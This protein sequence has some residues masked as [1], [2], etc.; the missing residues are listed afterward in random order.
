M[1]ANIVS[2]E[3]FNMKDD[4]IFINY[5]LDDKYKIRHTLDISNINNIK[6]RNIDSYIF[7]C[8]L[9]IFLYIFSKFSP[10][11]IINI[12]GYLSE[13]QLSYLK[14]WYLKGLGEFFYKNNL[15]HKI[16]LVLDKQAK[17]KYINSNISLEN[18]ALLLNGGGKDSSVSCEILKKPNINFEWLL[19][20]NSISQINV[21]KVSNIKKKV[22]ILNSYQNYFLPENIKYDTFN[23]HKPF[24]LYTSSLACLVGGLKN[25]KY[26]I[27][28]NE[29]SSNYGNLTIN[30]I[31][32]NHQYTKS[33]E[34]EKDFSRYVINNLNVNIKYFSLL[35]PI[36]ELQIAKIFSKLPQYHRVFVSCNR[37]G[38]SKWCQKCSKCAF[39]YLALYPFLDRSYLNKIIGKDLFDDVN[40]L[41]IYEEL[42]GIRKVKPFECVGTIK[43]NLIAM[44]LSCKKSEK[45]KGIILNHFIKN[46]PQIFK[47]KKES[48]NFFK[49]YDERNNIPSEIENKIRKNISNL[50]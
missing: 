30:N 16:N 23:G 34:F 50:I 32:I 11:K 44:Y 43:E 18:S 9:G 45:S 21:C 10:H 7:F 42:T 39:I 22:N 48:N 1:R 15:P 33:L 19:I 37:K 38:T 27:Y 5:L 17:K 3:S 28:S 47:Y 24:T 20:G 13:I 2:Y 41:P 40:M 36:Y 46:V 8:G 29:K 31:S 35:K 14:K 25:F 4:K 6:N 49:E 12:A 26:I